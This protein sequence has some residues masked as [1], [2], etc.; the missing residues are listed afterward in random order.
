MIVAEPKSL[1]E[2]KAM[3]DGYDRVLMVGCGTCVEVCLT[4]GE[5]SVNLTATALRLS[6]KVDG[7]DIE[8]GEQTV[9]RQCDFEYLDEVKDTDK[10]QAIVSLACGV[11]IQG[12]A[13]K[14]PNTPVFPGVNTTFMGFNEEYGYYTEMCKGCGEC[15][16]HLTGG[17]CPVARCAK[18]LLNGPCGGTNNGKCEIGNDKDCGWVL[19]Y[20]KMEQLGTLD[21]FMEINMPKNYGKAGNIRSMDL[22]K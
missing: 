9:I 3:V 13:R 16:L 8:V 1:D 20:N 10:Y 17:V 2:I 7:R 18:S 15:I 14:F 11:G 12:I 4:G 22:R 19:I 6:R 5:R 21:K